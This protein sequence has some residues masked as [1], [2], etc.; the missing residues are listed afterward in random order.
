V[1]V[2]IDALEPVVHERE[3]AIVGDRLQLVAAPPARPNG[4][5]TARWR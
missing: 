3:S 5:P 4:S 1:R 2:R